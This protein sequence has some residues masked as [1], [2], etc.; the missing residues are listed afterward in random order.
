MKYCLKLLCATLLL[1]ALSFSSLVGCFGEIVDIGAEDESKRAEVTDAPT[2]EQTEQQTEKKTEQPTEKLP[3]PEPVVEDRL[4]LLDGKSDVE[5][6]LYLWDLQRKDILSVDSYTM[7][8]EADIKGSYQGIPISAKMSGKTT[9][10]GIISKSKPFFRD[11]THMDMELNNGQ[12][13]QSVNTAEGYANGKLYFYEESAG[14]KNG[15]AAPC[16]YEEW[17]EYRNEL[18]DYSSPELLEDSCENIIVVQNEEQVTLYLSEFSEDG[19]A[20]IMSG[21]ESFTEFIGAPCIDVEVQI[22]YRKDLLPVETSVEF[23]FEAMPNLPKFSMRATLEDIGK[24]KATTVSFGGYVAMNNLLEMKK[25]ELKLDKMKNASHGSFTYNYTESLGYD[26]GD[27]LREDAGELSV[28]YWNAEDGYRFTIKDALSGYSTEYSGGI[29]SVT[30]SGGGVTTQE[31]TDAQA[32]AI[33]DG[34][35]DPSDLSWERALHVTK[36]GNLIQI[37]LDN[38]NLNT[39]AVYLNQFG[40]IELDLRKNTGYLWHDQRN[41]NS[42]S[43]TYYANIVVYDEGEFYDLEHKAFIDNVVYE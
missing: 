32:K 10:V 7:Y 39:F 36:N 21:F 2:E 35:I 42:F 40:P 27:M 11:Y 18:S 38:V 4:Y 13:T 23:V 6:A 26:A 20:R 19:L 15:V 25:L 41:N 3:D 43:A 22:V 29:L 28:E 1:L 24:T 31:Y 30:A 34:Y 33:I 8:T 12:Y 9:A 16:D 5:K 37:G 17:L 14:I